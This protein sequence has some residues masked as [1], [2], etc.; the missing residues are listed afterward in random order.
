MSGR[1][2]FARAGLAALLCLA[3]IA[4]ARADDIVTETGMYR[5]AVGGHTVR[6]EGMVMKRADATGRL[7]IAIF[8]NGRPGARFEA[9]EFKLSTTW[10]QLILRDLAR[11]GWLAVTV[12]RRGF[13]L[14]DGPMQ[15]SPSCGPGG[16]M[17]MLTADAD[18]VQATLEM[19]ARRPD[20][21]GSRMI[22]MGISAGGGASVALSARNPPGL[23]AAIDMGGAEHY[24][25]CP[26]LEPTV[27]ADFAAM[28][29]TSRVPNLWLFAKNDSLHP[30]EQ[31]TA[32]H[33]AFTEAG[34]IAKLVQFEPIGSEGHTM[35]ET[36][37][38]RR[39]WLA[40]LDTFLREQNLPTWKESDADLLAD[41][42]KMRRP[43]PQAG[44]DY[45]LRYLGG[46]GE[47]VLARSTTSTQMNAGYGATI[48]AARKQAVEGCQARAPVCVVV[49]END[50][51]VGT[52]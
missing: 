51:W 14:S 8:N 22:T 12:Q 19:L 24:D 41:R 42:L 50:R 33:A 18:E 17:K 9:T 48:E 16:W 2:G 29:K 37:A 43:L 7:P 21:D 46:P 1:T 26:Q 23:K 20:A 13:G 36:L 31:V 45:L 3:L 38:G 52:E 11:R 30:P 47:R 4:G 10:M 44:T 49:M 39:L 40:A 25:E 35:F 15:L 28:G 34:G 6:L 32:I 5:V 27:V